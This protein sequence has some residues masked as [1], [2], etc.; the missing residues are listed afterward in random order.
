M[1]VRVVKSH[2]IQSRPGA[3]ILDE[4]ELKAATEAYLGD[5]T[6][7]FYFKGIDFLKEKWANCIRVKG[8]ILKNNVETIFQ[9]VSSTNL[10]NFPRTWPSAINMQ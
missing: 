6:D 7:D 3:R 5:Q 10:L 8:I 4:D 1:Q 9:S 2:A